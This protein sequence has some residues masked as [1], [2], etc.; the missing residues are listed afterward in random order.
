M[1][2]F[3]KKHSN[4]NNTDTSAAVEAADSQTASPAIPEHQ[5]E[6]SSGGRI[7]SEH[8]SSSSSPT[9][10]S[11]TPRHR[12]PS[13]RQQPPLSDSQ[14]V[15]KPS[16]SRSATES[17]TE[18]SAP[19]ERLR[20]HRSA[21]S[22]SRGPTSSSANARNS[23]DIS[24]FSFR[25]S[26]TAPNSSPTHPL[27]LPPE[28][29]K[30]LSAL[31]AAANMDRSSMEVDR[32]ATTPSSPPLPSSPPTPQPAPTHNGNGS[33]NGENQNG[34]ADST[35]ADDAAPPPPPHRSGTSSPP[36]TPM[37]Q[38]EA[39]KA[40]GNKAFGEKNFPRAIDLYTKGM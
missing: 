39:F 7:H 6:T 29:R 37:Q 14:P 21:S 9:K 32:E 18:A 28:E 24:A 40:A 27:N 2:L 19:S 15:P 31:S 20:D 10:N 4:R 8:L 34:T 12:V 13:S 25:R 26:R 17:A 5:P 23:A 30:R 3:A 33:G 22:S 1:K 36:S 11:R 16:I 38:A 35:P